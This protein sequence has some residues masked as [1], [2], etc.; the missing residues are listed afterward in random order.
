MGVGGWKMLENCFQSTWKT[1]SELYSSDNKSKYYS[2]PKHIFNLEK[3]LSNFLYLGDSFQ[4]CQNYLPAL[5][6]ERKNLMNNLT[7]LRRK[8]L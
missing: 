6:T 7:L 5:L 1:I 2:N 8:Y 3:K 4:N